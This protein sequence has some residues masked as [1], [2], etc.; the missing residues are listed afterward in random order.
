MVSFGLR[1]F[2]FAP[3]QI[4]LVKHRNNLSQNRHRFC[5][6]EAVKLSRYCRGWK[7]NLE[8]QFITCLS[9]AHLRRYQT[10]SQFYP[11]A[12]FGGRNLEVPVKFRPSLPRII[13]FIYVLHKFFRLIASVS[14]NAAARLWRSEI[15]RQ[16]GYHR[17]A[18]RIAKYQGKFP[19]SP[20]P[21]PRSKRRIFSPAPR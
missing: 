7:I 14:L 10:I 2:G 6:S 18:R 1:T 16:T 3:R 19:A 13:R 8:R 15:F 5:H 12:F 11:Y 21:L 20:P 9:T 17:P 4:N